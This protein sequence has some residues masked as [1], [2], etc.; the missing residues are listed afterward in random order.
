LPDASEI[1]MAEAR[2]DG[3]TGGPGADSVQAEMVDML[4]ARGAE[5][6][7]DGALGAT[8]CWILREANEGRQVDAISVDMASRRFGFGGVVAGI[9]AFD[10]GNRDGLR[11]NVETMPKNVPLSRYG[12]CVSPA[13]RSGAVV[14]GNMEATYESIPRAMEPGQSVTLKGALASRFQSATVYLTK[15]DGTVAQK[16][17]SG[18]RFQ[19][20]FLLDRPGVYRLEVMGNDRHGPSIVINLPLYVGVPEPPARG[21][22]GA[23][24]DPKEAE[25]RLLELLNKARVTAGVRPLRSDDE[26]VEVARSHSEDMSDHGFFAH[27]SPSTGTPDDRARRAKVLASRFGENIGLG[28]TP[29]EVHE[30]LMNSPG[31]RMNMLLAEYT[32]V[33]IAAEKSEGSLVVTVNFARRPNPADLPKSTAEVETAVRNLRTQRGLKPHEP[34][35]VYRGAAQS[36][37]DAL[38]SGA[39]RK[40]IAR[41]VQAGVEREVNRLR[42]SRPEA[43]IVELE[44]LELSQL[45]TVPHLLSPNLGRLGVGTRLAEDKKG[46]RLSTIFMLDGPACQP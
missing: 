18:V 27:V 37:A 45:T 6:Q 19:E 35:P 40:D 2:P 21:A 12:V 30:G 31:H 15:A 29:E 42:T 32:H 5:F 10:M 33:G 43:C 16:D 14:L 41:A 1:Y 3:V 39:A 17:L 23:V 25:L 7:A 4:R 22:S 8:A 44:L 11:E 36:G 24:S 28:S 34:D 26:L 38:A 46:K 20:T 9:A 13:G